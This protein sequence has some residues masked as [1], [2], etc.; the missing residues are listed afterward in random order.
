MKINIKESTP[1]EKYEL[2]TLYKDHG[3]DVFYFVQDGEY[4]NVN[5]L[6]E[7]GYLTTGAIEVGSDFQSI[8]EVVQGACLD[9]PKTPVP[10]KK[11]TIEF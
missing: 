2:G 4:F 1:K 8:Q 6:T 9:I 5:Y 10:A 11:L 3:G 7:G